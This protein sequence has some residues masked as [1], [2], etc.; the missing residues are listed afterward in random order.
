MGGK[1]GRGRP[2]RK[3]MD[4]MMEDRC[5]KLKENA[6][7]GEEWRVTGQNGIGQKGTDNMVRTEW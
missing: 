4:W 6:Q 5:K 2:R 7:H 3:L 1:R